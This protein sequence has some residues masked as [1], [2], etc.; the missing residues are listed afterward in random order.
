MKKKIAI[1]VATFLVQWGFAQTYDDGSLKAKKGNFLTEL[2]VNPFKANLSLNNSL[3]QIKGR[4]FIKDDLALRLGVSVNVVD[5]TGSYGS[6]Y[7]SQSYFI[8]TSTKQSSTDFNFGIEKHFRGTNRLSPYIGVDV[9]WGRQRSRNNVTTNASTVDVKNGYLEL[10]PVYDNNGYGNHFTL[11][12]DG[13]TRF[14][15]M[16]IAGFD[17][18]MAKSFFVGYEF[19]LGYSNFKYKTP[20][21][22]GLGDDSRG[23]FNS[24]SNKSVTSFKPS[25]M[26]GIRIGYTF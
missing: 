14:G 6:P 18:Y 13:Y 1:L 17:F 22:T 11:T 23:I 2:N 19:N 21:V 8:S 5:S 16:A 24:I 12:P 26:N 3:N 9:S 4:Y 15:A 7:G 10:M 20:E 25:L